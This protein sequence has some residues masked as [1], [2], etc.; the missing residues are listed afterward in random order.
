MTDREG[1]DEDI[2]LERASKIASAMRKFPNVPS[3]GHEAELVD[4]LIAAVEALREQAGELEADFK[5]M[6]EQYGAANKFMAE[7]L[8]ER[9]AAVALNK[10]M[11]EVLGDWFSTSGNERDAKWW[12]TWDESARAVLKKARP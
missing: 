10:E 3:D 2:D 8:E 1:G 12:C 6:S 5:Q 9:D 11:A 7:F 4:T